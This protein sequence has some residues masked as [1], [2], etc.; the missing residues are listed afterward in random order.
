VR[1]N[2]QRQCHKRENDTEHVCLF[3]NA[4]LVVSSRST[5]SVGLRQKKFTESF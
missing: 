1:C 4:S 3:R 5:E 2:G